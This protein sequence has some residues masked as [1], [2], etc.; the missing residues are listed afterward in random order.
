M[1]LFAGLGAVLEVRRAKLS[2]RDPGNP[3]AASS[4]KDDA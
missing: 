3:G 4:A 2:K 1:P